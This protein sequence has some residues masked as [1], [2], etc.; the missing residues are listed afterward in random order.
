M[1]VFLKQQNRQKVLM[2]PDGNCMFRSV[3]HQL[4]KDAKYHS[5][6]R[7]ATVA[8]AAQNKEV[9]KGYLP[10]EITTEQHLRQMQNPGCW[11]T[12]LELKAMAS[13]FKLT[14]Y[15]LTDT[16]VQG[17]CR[18]TRFLPQTSQ[19][20]SNSNDWIAG[21]LQRN[22][23]P[24]WIEISHSNASHYDSIEYLGSAPHSPPALSTNSSGSIIILP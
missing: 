21:V 18:W 20:C 14:I 15:I 23:L 7:Q 9:L 11:G 16:L 12:Q 13:M 3:A 8:F 17:E 19:D 24:Q 6:L 10:H 22:D 2:Q 4:F 5:K 1:A